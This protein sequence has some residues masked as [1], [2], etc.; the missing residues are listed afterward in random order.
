LGDPNS[1][2]F[3]EVYLT[4]DDDS[5]WLIALR[6]FPKAVEVS[7]QLMPPRPVYLAR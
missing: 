5:I 2:V 7:Q 6:V 1:F 4:T 3:N